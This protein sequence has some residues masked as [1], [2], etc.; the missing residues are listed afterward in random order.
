MTGI[1]D[2]LAKRRYPDI[3]GASIV[4]I[5]TRNK[6]FLFARLTATV[7]GNDPQRILGVNMQHSRE[8]TL[9]V[10]NASIHTEDCRRVMQMLC[11]VPVPDSCGW[12]KQVSCCS[13]TI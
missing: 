3:R 13:Y 2:N 7:D 10:D 8:I 6:C 5:L 1:E 9:L 4:G 12:T 11:S